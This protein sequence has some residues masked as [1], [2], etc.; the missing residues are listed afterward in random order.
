MSLKLVYLKIRALVEAPQLLLYY[1]GIN[2]Q[3]LMSWDHY[4][5]EWSKINFTLCMIMTKILISEPLYLR[6]CKMIFTV[7]QP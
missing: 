5:D 3:Y 1:A 7:L 6:I 2:Y 4:G